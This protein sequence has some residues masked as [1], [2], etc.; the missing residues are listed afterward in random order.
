MAKNQPTQN[1]A[2]IIVNIQCLKYLRRH[3]GRVYVPTIYVYI[4]YVRVVIHSIR[5]LGDKYYYYR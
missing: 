1:K 4:K 3:D 5:R 2:L